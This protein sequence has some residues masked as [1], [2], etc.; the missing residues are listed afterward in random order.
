LIGDADE[1][2]GAEIVP[3]VLYITIP[4]AICTVFACAL[5]SIILQPRNP[6][7]VTRAT[8][9]VTSAVVLCGC[10]GT[11]VLL[12]SGGS[13]DSLVG[14]LLM[15]VLYAP[16]TMLG[17]FASPCFTFMMLRNA[18]YRFIGPGRAA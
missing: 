5:A 3:F 4:T 10:V 15:L 14:M 1:L 16:V 11:I 2:P 9:L 6:K 12:L 17:I 18:N 7:T 13:V 8:L